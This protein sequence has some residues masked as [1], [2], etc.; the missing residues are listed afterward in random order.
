MKTYTIQAKESG[1]GTIHDIQGCYDREIRFR[2]GCKYAV[3][4]AAY[5]GGKGYTTHMTENETIQQSAKCNCSHEIID[6]DG[7]GYEINVN[8]LVK[9]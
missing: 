8:K 9:I 3:V 5:Y 7:N 6:S 2:S 4:L 1:I